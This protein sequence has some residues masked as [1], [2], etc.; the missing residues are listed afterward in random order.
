M[1]DASRGFLDPVR[2][3]MRQVRAV[4]G[5]ATLDPVLLTAAERI[6]YEGSLRREEAD[7]GIR[8][9]AEAGIS[10]RRIGQRL[11]HSRKVVRAV[12]R[13][14]RTDVF[15]QDRAAVQAASTLPCSNDQTK[16]QITKLK[17]AKCQMYGRGKID[18]LQARLNGL[19]P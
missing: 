2:R 9:L 15:G 11:G 4:V 7:A 18:L 8:A 3:S 5:A 10:I 6:Q 16:G 1:E 19:T 13:G 14:E 12:P 17:L